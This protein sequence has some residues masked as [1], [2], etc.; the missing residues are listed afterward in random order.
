[1]SKNKIDITHWDEPIYASNEKCF[2]DWKYEEKYQC[3]IMK[4]SLFDTISIE[5][6]KKIKKSLSKHRNYLTEEWFCGYVEVPESCEDHIYSMRLSEKITYFG[7]GKMIWKDGGEKYFAGFDTM[8]YSDQW[9]PEK[10]T[11]RSL[12]SRTNNLARLIYIEI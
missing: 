10:V 12:M 3:F 1:M 9:S 2:M 4:R 7:K 11:L 8:R 6:A 5:R